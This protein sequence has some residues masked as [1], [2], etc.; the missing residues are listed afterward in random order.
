MGKVQGDQRQTWFRGHRR[1]GPSFVLAL[2]A[3]NLARFPR[4]LAAGP[5]GHASAHAP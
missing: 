1:V 5:L 4:P 2:A 3:C